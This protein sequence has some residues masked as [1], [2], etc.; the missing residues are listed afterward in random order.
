MAYTCYVIT[1]TVY[2]LSL[3]YQ[4]KAIKEDTSVLSY[5]IILI[6]EITFNA[7]CKLV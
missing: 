5:D 7:L 4:H 1:Y 6:K 2:Y 3:S